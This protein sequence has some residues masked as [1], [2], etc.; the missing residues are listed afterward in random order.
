MWDCRA[1]VTRP[2][3]G[4]SFWIL[5]DTQFGQ[6]YEPELRLLNVYAPEVGDP[7]DREVTAVIADWFARLDPRRQWPLYVVTVQTKVFEPKQRM[8]FNRYLATVWRFGEQAGGISLNQVVN[9][10]LDEHPEWGRGKGV[11]P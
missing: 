2:Y 6:R 1:K 8:T 9:Q 5:A 10:Y 3:D 4:D 11:K 7:G